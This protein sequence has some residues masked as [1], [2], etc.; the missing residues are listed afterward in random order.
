MFEAC[1][2]GMQCFLLLKYVPQLA[3][4]APV[5]SVAV[6]EPVLE[7]ASTMKA[8]GVLSVQV[9]SFP[10]ILLETDS[11]TVQSDRSCYLRLLIVQDSSASSSPIFC[12]PRAGLAR[13]CHAF[14]D[15]AQTHCRYRIASRLI[16]RHAQSLVQL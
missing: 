4:R 2:P 15:A 5:H 6:R 8:A 11:Q 13:Y 16:S 7:K 3:M 1:V 10:T 9:Q 12:G 14:C